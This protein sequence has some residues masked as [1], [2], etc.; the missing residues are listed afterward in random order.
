M[1]DDMMIRLTDEDGEDLLLYVIEETKIAGKNYL[2]A[3]DAPEGDSNG[4]LL[5]DDSAPEDEEAVYVLVDD[6]KETDYVMCVFSEL[7]EDI[8]WQE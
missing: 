1:N 8:G 7:L 3:A 5:R 6:P 2:L 4:Y